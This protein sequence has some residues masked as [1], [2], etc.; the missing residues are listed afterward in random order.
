MIA[1]MIMMI[2]MIMIIIIMMIVV[3]MVIR[4]HPQWFDAKLDRFIFEIVIRET[5]VNLSEDFTLLDE[6]LEL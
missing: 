3:I 4:L 2:M 1:I 5:N 6:L